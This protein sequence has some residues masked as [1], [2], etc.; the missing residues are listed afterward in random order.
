MI[1]ASFYNHNID[2]YGISLHSNTTIVLN[3]EI[4]YEKKLF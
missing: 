3:G 1:Y 4:D 2:F